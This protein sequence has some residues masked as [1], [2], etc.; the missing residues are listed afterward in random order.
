MLYRTI[1]L[2]LL[3]C[4][5]VPCHAAPDLYR[6]SDLGPGIGFA[7]NSQRA[8][9]GRHVDTYEAFVCPDG[10][11]PGYLGLYTDGGDIND[12]GRVLGYDFYS[13]F[14]ADS[15]AWTWLTGAMVRLTDPGYSRGWELNNHDQIVGEFRPDAYNHAFLWSEATGMT[16]LG[17]LGGTTSRAYS[18]NDRGE[19]VG[20]STIPGSSTSHMFRWTPDTGM[21]DL[22]AYNGIAYDINDSSQIVAYGSTAGGYGGVIYQSGVFQALPLIDGRYITPRRI[23]DTGV[24]I[25]YTTSNT[26]V[27]WDAQHGGRKINN[28]I[29]PATNP[30]L[31]VVAVYDINA[32]GDIAGYAYNAAD[33]TYHAVVL[34]G[35]DPDRVA[36]IISGLTVDPAS[37]APPDG[38]MRD[39][40]LAYTV[41]DDRDPAPTAHIVSIAAS[42]AG[43][44][45]GVDGVVE[46][47]RHVSLRAACDEDDEAGRAYT[48]TVEASDAAGNRSSAT[49]AVTV[50]YV[51]P[52]RQAPVIAG[53][54]VD[55]ASIWPPTGQMKPVTVSYTV[56]DDLD[57]A[58]T[59][60]IASITCSQ[61]SY[62]DG[63]DGV[64]VDAHDVSVLA[65]RD[66]TDKA[67]R[68]Y[69]I[70]VEAQDAAG[71][72]ATA[73]ATVTVPHN[74]PKP[75]KGQG[76]VAAAAA[77]ARD[78][79]VSIIA[80]VTGPCEL[81]ASIVNI[82]GRRIRDLAPTEVAEAGAATMRWDGR[83][84]R[85]TR[86]PAGR[87][88]VTVQSFG[89]DGTKSA[90][91]AP[92]QLLR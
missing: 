86:V 23:S 30:G 21:V 62:V 13:S 76:V 10:G 84:D 29:D 67:G 22:G 92:L 8:V 9:M 28:I 39:V 53:L 1:P 57:P 12:S 66:D 18:I 56:S 4:C 82:G 11:Q 68:I 45:D 31:T 51:A 90:A 74:R 25:G 79:S 75:P 54:S 83:S 7:I 69:T 81:H 20:S 55:P 61:A 63:R 37:L 78:G 44:V 47:S 72:I 34:R 73:S 14:L 42:Q 71:N 70:N 16:D 59:A 52:D 48:V 40:A 89:Q 77:P 85:G 2:A 80:S 27:V 5:S 19:V 50:P 38:T 36:P 6:M 87:Y 41:T 64:I 26:P 49:V 32:T 17:T 35:D 43:Y 60:R 24:V 33:G 15:Y 58:P 65:F 3:I 91:M 46:D 88:L